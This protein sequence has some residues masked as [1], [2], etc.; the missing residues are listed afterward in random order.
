M[1]P[2]VT[3]A[4]LT[5]EFFRP[6]G[7]SL[8]TPFGWG[9]MVDAQERPGALLRQ[10]TAARKNL[11]AL[12]TVPLGRADVAAAGHRVEYVQQHPRPRRGRPV[13]GAA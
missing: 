9:I 13:L 3:D 12:R 4:G 6:D 11:R 1:I 2:N 7:F 5:L 8:E 10:V